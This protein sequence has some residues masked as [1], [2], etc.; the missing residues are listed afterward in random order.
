LAV[1]TPE[2]FSLYENN[3]VYI[4]P[5]QKE[6]D[7]SEFREMKRKSNAKYQQSRGVFMEPQPY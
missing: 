4:S 2:I 5:F 6:T 7:R 1:K 3:A